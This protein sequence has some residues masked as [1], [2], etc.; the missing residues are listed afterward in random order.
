M[1]VTVQ[2]II[3]IQVQSYFE[4]YFMYFEINVYECEI[5]L[6]ILFLTAWIIITK[7]VKKSD[8]EIMTHKTTYQIKY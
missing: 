4:M 7:K 6:T 2:L 3:H 5:F 1:T 8:F